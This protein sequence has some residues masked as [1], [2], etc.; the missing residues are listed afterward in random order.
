[1]SAKDRRRAQRQKEKAIDAMI[2]LQ[3]MGLGT[4]A[5]ARILELLN[6]LN[7]ER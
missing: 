1:M 3:D 5:I 4:D 6:T 7:F 2:E